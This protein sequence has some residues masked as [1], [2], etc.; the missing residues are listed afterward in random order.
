MTRTARASTGGKRLVAVVPLGLCSL[1]LPAAGTRAQECVPAP[2]GLVSWWPG[3][4]NAED[5]KG[6]NDGI[7]RNS[8]SFAAG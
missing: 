4:G 1:L 5:I 3:D 8:V 7:L 6:G 2:D